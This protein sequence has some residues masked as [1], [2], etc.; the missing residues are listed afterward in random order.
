MSTRLFPGGKGG[1]CVRLTTLPPSCAVVKK[2]GNLN[3]L[4]PSEPLQACNVTALPFT[5]IHSHS[6]DNIHSGGQEIH[7]A[8]LECLLQQRIT[9]V[10]VYYRVGLHNTKLL[11]V[12][13]TKYSVIQ[14]SAYGCVHNRSTCI[15]GLLYSQHW[16]T[17]LYYR[18]NNHELPKSIIVWTTMSYRTLLPYL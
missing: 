3:F 18:V 13:Y 9:D 5:F 16:V 17:E 1:R 4:E 2:S 11:N 12:M 8:E 14:I 10:Q 6:E 15:L 7:F